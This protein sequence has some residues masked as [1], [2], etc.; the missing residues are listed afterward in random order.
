MPI[1]TELLKA[2]ATLDSFLLLN[3]SAFS[4]CKKKCINPELK[5]GSLTTGESACTDRCL[6]KFFEA[7]LLVAEATAD[8][9]IDKHKT[10]NSQ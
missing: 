7:N 2:E 9:M 6:Q 3:E 4:M 10:M 8:H 1:S 5:E